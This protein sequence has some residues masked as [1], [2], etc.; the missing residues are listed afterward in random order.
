MSLS[1]IILFLLVNLW[2]HLLPL[3]LLV[4]YTVFRKVNVLSITKSIDRENLC[5]ICRHYMV[6][7]SGIVRCWNCCDF[8][9]K[10]HV[11][12]LASHL[13]INIHELFTF[14]AESYSYQM[15][16]LAT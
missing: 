4:L 6:D 1:K 11:V 2:H 7:L 12:Y 8:P 10:F 16:L 5:E 9:K 15:L 13:T 14:I 3:Q